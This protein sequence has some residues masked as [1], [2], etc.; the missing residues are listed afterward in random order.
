MKSAVE[1]DFFMNKLNIYQT[2]NGCG[3]GCGY[4][5]C[6]ELLFKRTSE[7]SMNG[8]S[9]F[10]VDRDEAAKFPEFSVRRNEYQAKL[11]C[12]S[13]TKGQIQ[14]FVGESIISQS[15]ALAI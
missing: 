12:G 9:T 5:C 3:N 11:K 6:A 8:S 14:E 4:M 15:A 13:F 2:A 1:K 7:P 10:C